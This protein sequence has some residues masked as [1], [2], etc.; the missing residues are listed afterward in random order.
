MEISLVDATILWETLT[1][2]VHERGVSPTSNNSEIVAI[3]GL[4]LYDSKTFK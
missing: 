4:C 1:R 2:F 3:R